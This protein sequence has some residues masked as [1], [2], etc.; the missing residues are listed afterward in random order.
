MPIF[1]IIFIIILLLSVILH[2]V[3][4]GFVADRMGD[5]TARHQGRL[6]LNPLPHIDPIGSILVPALLF[7]SHS[8]FLFGWAKPVPYNPHNLRDQKHGD[9]KVAFAG[10]ATNLVIAI[11]FGMIIRFGIDTL[12]VAF[13]G[14]SA[15]ITLLNMV[16]AIFNLIPVPPL[17]GSKILFSFLPVRFY[18]IQRTMEQYWFVSLGI[19]IIFIY[20]FLGGIIITLFELLTGAPFA[21]ALLGMS[22]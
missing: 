21:V 7:L 22:L 19:L 17:D 13:I 2:E 8:P 12:P 20:F 1:I 3:M 5:P 18:H 6:T 16:L 15:V 10:P 4:H 9:A 14:I 11:I